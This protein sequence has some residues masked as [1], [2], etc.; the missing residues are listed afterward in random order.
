MRFIC[1]PV[2]VDSF[3][4][5]VH[6]MVNGLNTTMLHMT[7]IHDKLEYV[8]GLHNPAVWQA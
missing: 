8:H 5:C 3:G 2:I 1:I 7:D 4:L 6:D